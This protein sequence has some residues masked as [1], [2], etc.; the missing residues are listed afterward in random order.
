M[1]KPTEYENDIF[2]M[3]WVDLDT[4][5]IIKSWCQ[6]PTKFHYH[7]SAVYLINI[8]K[9]VNQYLITMYYQWYGCNNIEVLEENLIY[10]LNIVVTRD[11]VFKLVDILSYELQ[12]QVGWEKASFREN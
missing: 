8:L 12:H 7:P 4:S 11:R 5:D 9:D 1:I 10:T 3:R 6:D 2:Y